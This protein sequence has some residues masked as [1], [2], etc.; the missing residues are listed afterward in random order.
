M[1]EY[2]ENTISCWDTNSKYH[3]QLF[4]LE[5]EWALIKRG[6]VLELAGYKYVLSL[7]KYCLSAKGVRCGCGTGFDL[8]ISVVTPRSRAIKGWFPV[9]SDNR[10]Y[11]REHDRVVT[12]WSAVHYSAPPLARLCRGKP[13]SLCNNAEWRHP[14]TCKELDGVLASPARSSFPRQKKQ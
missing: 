7:S 5:W 2:G 10:I 14:L 13:W 4:S 1:Y 3:L 6:H 8:F 9:I 12:T 11:N